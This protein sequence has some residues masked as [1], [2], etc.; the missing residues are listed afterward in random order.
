ME[1]SAF[2]SWV[3]RVPGG[4]AWPPSVLS[5]QYSVMCV[6]VCVYDVCMYAYTAE[7]IQ[8]QKEWESSICMDGRGSVMLSEVTQKR[9]SIVWCHSYRN[10]KGAAD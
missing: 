4:G 10:L 8:P 7:P 6:C 2:N 9:I 5:P 3:E 1:G